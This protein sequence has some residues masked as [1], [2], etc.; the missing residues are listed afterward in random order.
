MTLYTFFEGQ[1]FRRESRMCMHRKG[2]EGKKKKNV[3]KE[4]KDPT[5]LQSYS[6]FMISRRILRGTTYDPGH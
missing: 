5:T 4:E 6:Y 2:A 1:M 3:K